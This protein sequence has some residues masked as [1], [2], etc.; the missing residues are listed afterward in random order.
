MIVNITQVRQ[1]I[2]YFHNSPQ[3]TLTQWLLDFVGIPW[4]M[5]QLMVFIPLQF[6]NQLFVHFDR[7]GFIY[8]IKRSA[9]GI[10][11]STMKISPGNDQSFL[12]S[13]TI[14]WT[15]AAFVFFGFLGIWFNSCI[16]VTTQ[17]FQIAKKLSLILFSIY[18][19]QEYI[20][21]PI[22]RDGINVTPLSA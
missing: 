17:T 1:V 11:A 12:R 5:K 9:A 14:T 21:I 18:W 7:H 16:W 4:H 20:H 6:D 3:Y 10:V 13:Q 2:T 19:V 8:S 15:N 22:R